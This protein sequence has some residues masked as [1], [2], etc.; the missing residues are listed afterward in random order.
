MESTA[1][2]NRDFI[3]QCLLLYQQQDKL[4]VLIRKILM[5]L[6]IPDSEVS[7]IIDSVQLSNE[8]FKESMEMLSLVIDL[9]FE[10]RLNK[11]HLLAVNRLTENIC[12]N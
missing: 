8:K 4:P 5:N 1:K 12:L 7:S 3:K 9:S 11:L 10:A 2:H 6:D